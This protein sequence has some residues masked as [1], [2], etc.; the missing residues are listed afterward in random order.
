MLHEHQLTAYSRLKR[1]QSMLSISCAVSLEYYFLY[2]SNR[3]WILLSPF[4]TVPVVLWHW[5]RQLDID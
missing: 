4:I 1:T 2:F 3:K 5:S